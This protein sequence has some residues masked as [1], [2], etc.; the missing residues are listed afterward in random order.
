MSD[1]QGNS[2]Y[3]WDGSHRPD[4]QGTQAPPADAARDRLAQ[5]AQTP[6]PDC[7]THTQI[8]PNSPGAKSFAQ[9][10][11]E[12]LNQPLQID[13][14][15][16]YHVQR[17]DTLSAIAIRELSQSG[18]PVTGKSINDVMDQIVALN[19]D[20]YPS[21]ECDRGTIKETWH[22]RLPDGQQQ[23]YEAPPPPAAPRPR[24][25]YRAPDPPP[26]EVYREA[27]PRE[28]YRE[29]PPP[30]AYDRGYRV[31]PPVAEAERMPPPTAMAPNPRY[32]E[33]PPPPPPVA[34]LG[35]ALGAVIRGIFEPRR[36][37]GYGPGWG[38]P[39]YGSGWVDPAW[40]PEIYVGG[41]YR[42]R[43]HGRGGRY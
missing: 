2:A 6:G 5:A 15:G 1:V 3:R 23:T 33:A 11:R 19:K 22:L 8:D 10:T 38:A 20:K 12:T 32:Y 13:Q 34:E 21:L 9:H 29:A 41:G 31:P 24:E 30:N 35:F 40:G 43:W 17:Y 37:W 7:R 27:P 4:V 42:P 39:A 36:A 16:T 14:D 25:A 18:R 28:T 26:R